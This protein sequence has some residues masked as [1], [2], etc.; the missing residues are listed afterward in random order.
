VKTLMSQW[1]KL[2]ENLSSFER[3][4]AM[5]GLVAKGEMSAGSYD[6]LHDL[7][8]TRATGKIRKP[9]V[10]G[11][12]ALEYPIMAGYLFLRSGK[13]WKRKYI[14]LF[15]E[16]LEYHASKQESETKR[17]LISSPTA[18]L[19]LTERFFVS[20]SSSRR[21]VNDKEHGF[22]IS[23]FNTTHYFAAETQDIAQ[24]WMHTLAKT[25]QK[26]QQ[27]KAYF[28]SRP[29]IVG[30]FPK[31]SDD[32]EREYLERLSSYQSSM[33]QPSHASRETSS[34][35]GL[36]SHNARQSI[37]LK[38]EARDLE[39]RRIEHHVMQM[40]FEKEASNAELLATD[41]Q[42]RIDSANVD[43]KLMSDARKRLEKLESVRVE[44]EERALLEA[45]MV[46]EYDDLVAE[47]QAVAAEVQAQEDI[48]IEI[49]RR[50]VAIFPNITSP[51]EMEKLLQKQMDADTPEMLELKNA[52]I[53]SVA[54]S[55]EEEQQEKAK[56]AEEALQV[57]KEKHRIAE[58]L[59]KEAANNDVKLEK[60][61]EVVKQDQE[62]QQVA[63]VAA[64]ERDN[65]FRRAEAL[66]RVLLE[67]RAAVL[68]SKEKAAAR[69]GA[70]KK[71]TPVMTMQP[72]KK[73]DEKIQSQIEHL[74]SIINRAGT[75]TKDS[76]HEISFGLLCREYEKEV[77]IKVE[78]SVE[79]DTNDH[80]NN[81]SAFDVV[82]LL[83]RGKRQRLLDYPGGNLFRGKDDA[84]KIKSIVA[85]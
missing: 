55:V 27:A 52:A 65:A 53:E 3:L 66:Q 31:S 79:M 23:D 67:S 70:E 38:A 18:L 13:T 41:L 12:T 10:T 37:R 9:S 45:K 60:A 56:E 5:R 16:R 71:L 22:M 54:K 1:K 20:D 40:E 26:I 34:E 76:C 58:Q 30:H 51:E 48:Q 78:D 19:V 68:R 81:P 43:P 28:D 64:S 15:T 84:V 82:G 50:S 6:M 80:P 7:A 72:V 14:L 75:L 73:E 24:Y 62:A 63:E 35:G 69:M 57:A 74:V 21:L 49:K 59:S 44:M 36:S 39:S 77:V 33:R 83:V 47:K 4:E 8:V 85:I 25:I 29:K 32:L 11:V 2:D 46:S 61:M 17:G 42:Q